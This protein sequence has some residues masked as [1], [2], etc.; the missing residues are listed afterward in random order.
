MFAR[1]ASQFVA[2]S[3]F[4]DEKGEPGVVDEALWGDGEELEPCLDCQGGR[5]E[6]LEV[7]AG[8]HERGFACC[9]HAMSAKGLEF[10]HPSAVR[11]VY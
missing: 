5:I 2:A 6:K 10:F 7:L 9:E 1:T 4:C 11:P 3:D 8:G